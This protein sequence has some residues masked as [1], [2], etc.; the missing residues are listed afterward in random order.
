[1]DIFERCHII[2]DYFNVN[3]EYEARNELIKLLDFMEH[4]GLSYTPLINNLIRKAGLF[5]YIDTNT[6]QWQEKYITEAFKVNAGDKTDIVLHREQSRLLQKL[7]EGSNIAISA[8]TSFGKS[9]IVDSFL[10]IKQ[11]D[12]VVI[13]VPTIAL[14]DETR[15]RLQRK[16]G[17]NY[18]LI[19]TTEQNLEE[20]NILIFPQERAINYLSKIND[21]DILIVDEFYKA[22]K[23]FDKERAPALIRAILYFSN[24]AKQ[25]YFLA[26]NITDLNKNP[27]TKGMEFISLDFNT[28]FLEKHELYKEIGTDDEKKDNVL[29]KLLE[30]KTG[31][32]L[33]YA[34]NYTNISK[35]SN[36]LLLNREDV[37]N[38]LLDSFSQ[39][40]KTNYGPDWPL[41]KLVK[42]GIGIHNGQLHRSISQIQI[43]DH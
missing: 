8:P 22:S 41:T 7:L 1:M 16:F 39:W 23:L 6:S 26:P 20:K 40:L 15:R 35:I 24:I 9:F 13:I 30:Q 27:I 14:A 12:N 28:V 33:I 38:S 10:S 18:K 11:P 31:K 2:N 36:L 4:N 5:P 29:L 43:I 25:R 34:G 42:K 21:I 17:R 19:T 37:D 3:N 32:S